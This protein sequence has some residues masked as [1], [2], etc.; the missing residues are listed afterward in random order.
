MKI[1]QIPKFEIYILIIKLDK[2]YTN[3]IKHSNLFFSSE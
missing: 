3:I 1:G 2:M